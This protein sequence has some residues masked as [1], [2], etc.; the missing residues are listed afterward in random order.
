MPVRN[1]KAAAMKSLSRAL[2]RMCHLLGERRVAKIFRE[3][4]S[5]D[6]DYAWGV[7][8]ACLLETPNDS[9]VLH[10]RTL[11]QALRR[12]ADEQDSPFYAHHVYA[13]LAH[14]AHVYGHTPKRVLE[15]GPGSSLGALACFLASGAESAVG[16]DIEPLHGDRGAFFEDLKAYLAVVAGFRLWGNFASTDSNPHRSYPGCWDRVDLAALAAQID[17]RAPMPSHALPFPDASFDFVYSH[18]VLEHIEEAAGTIAEIRRILDPVGL[19][20]H[21]IDLRYHGPSDDHLK[22]LR[23]TEEEYRAM[24]RPYGEGRGI[25]SL[26]DGTWQGEVYCNRLRLSDWVDLFKNNDFEILEVEP[27]CVLS[28]DAVR[29]GELVSPF[30]QKAINDLSVVVVRITAR[31]TDISP[32]KSTFAVSN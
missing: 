12:R 32:A 25:D 18:S 5:A 6:P 24:T 1:V 3:W 19:T 22:L 28:E 30:D 29:R 8:S 21:V 17:Y 26:L 13:H 16:V 11:I 27:F 7:L 4:A 23:W 20:S 31:P 10:D 9:K 2:G 15:I 14:I